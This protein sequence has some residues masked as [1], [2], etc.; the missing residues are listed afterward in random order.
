MKD[1]QYSYYKRC[2]DHEDRQRVKRRQAVLE[3]IAR[4]VFVSA[5]I[6]GAGALYNVLLMAIGG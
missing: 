6:V 3:F 5:V 2:T 4:F 1:Y